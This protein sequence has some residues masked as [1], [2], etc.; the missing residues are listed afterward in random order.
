[1]ITQNEI[2]RKDFDRICLLKGYETFTEKQITGLSNHIKG[3]IEKSSREQLSSDEVQS[4]HAY[5]E[6][7]SELKKALVLNNDMTREVVY[8]RERQVIFDDSIEKSEDGK[9]IKAR[10]GVY[11]NTAQ[12]RKAGRVGQKYGGLKKEDI[13]EIKEK[14]AQSN[15]KMNQEKLETIKEVIS[16]QEF[17]KLKADIQDL[18]ESGK[19]S[20]GI[21]GGLS[22]NSMKAVDKIL[23]SA[24]DKPK[25][26]MLSP[27][28][29]VDLISG[30]SA[31]KENADNKDDSSIDYKTKTIQELT[32]MIGM[33]DKSPELAAEVK[34]RS[35]DKQ[36]DILNEAIKKE[37]ENKKESTDNKDG[38]VKMNNLDWGKT[39]E[40][41]NKNLDKF[42]SLKTKEEKEDFKKKLKSGK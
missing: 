39:T 6:D 27:G 4:I 42:E 38:E 33:G 13:K 35:I 10:S 32:K 31:K 37:K 36:V 12:N 21:K 18:K 20:K 11:A 24:K 2:A 28:E 34:K 1:M 9:L 29:V 7:V 30:E 22:E 16:D 26:S 19:D 15:S 40:E 17:K 23:S 3:I 8:Y 41:R 5:N 14:E 25:L